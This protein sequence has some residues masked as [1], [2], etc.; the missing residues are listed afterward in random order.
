VSRTKASEDVYRAVADP[1]R[2]AFLNALLDGPKS[3][4]EL[5]ELAPI[6]KGAVSQHLS[7]LV[8]VGLVQVNPDDRDRRYELT[9]AP[10]H[11]IDEWLMAYRAFWES[12]LDRLDEAVKRR[13]R[14]P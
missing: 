1:N 5:V 13:K 12:R 9:P 8:E 14:R 10:L 2:R 3:F 4:G 6:T 11:E 7:I